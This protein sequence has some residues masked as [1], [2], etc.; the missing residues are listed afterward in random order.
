MEARKSTLINFTNARFE[1]RAI[2]NQAKFGEVTFAPQPDSKLALGSG[3]D[4]VLLPAIF[5][6][7]ADFRMA[8]FDRADFSEVS[9]EEVD[10]TRAIFTDA[11]NLANTTYR[12]LIV[13]DL[14]LEILDSTNDEVLKRLEDNFRALGQLELANQ[15]FYQRKVLER[16]EKPFIIQFGELVVMDLPF[17]YGVH[18]LNAVLVSIGFI[19]LFTFFYYRSDAVRDR[20]PGKESKFRWRISDIPLEFNMGEENIGNQPS[21]IQRAWDAFVFSFSVYTK[22][23]TGQRVARS[24]QRVVI[25]EWGLGLIM[26]AGF[27]Y[28]LTNTVPIL[29][30]LLSAVL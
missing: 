21:K 4:P 19:L 1:D 15:V 20:A 24:L 23:G 8:Q 16:K 11:L 6:N 25:F 28:T 3:P 12:R 14:D 18:P 30:R 29:Q 10:F 26:I 13:D 9:F 27:L 5:F 22:L 2:F 17:G 7:R